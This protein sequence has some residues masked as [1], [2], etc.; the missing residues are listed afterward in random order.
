MSWRVVRWVNVRGPSLMMGYWG[1]P[2]KSAQVRHPYVLTEALGAEMIYRTGDLV[3]QAPD[4]NYLY[5]GRRDNMIKSR[6]Y[7]IG[8]GEIETVLYSHPAVEEAAVIAI[9]DDDQGGIKAVVVTHNGD[10]TCADAGSISRRQSFCAQHLPKYMI[11]H[12][13]EFRSTLP[14]TGI[15]LRRDT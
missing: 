14:K 9:P 13:F 7:I 15:H 1:L 2:E 3:K 5:L 6:A 8:L 12:S 10:K 4:G 11:P